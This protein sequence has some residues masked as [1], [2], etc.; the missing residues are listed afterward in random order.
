MAFQEDPPAGVPDW[1][2][3][4]GDMMSLLLTFFIML[5]SLSEVQAE[6][7]YRAVLEAIYERMGF[8]SGPIAPP[9]N[10]YPLNSLIE[11]LKKL[12]SHTKGL[13]GRGGIR[14]KGP[15][16]E[17][18]RVYRRKDGSALTI[19][20]ALVF[21]EGEATLNP[22]ILH[23]LRDVIKVLS[24]KPNKIEIRGH[25]SSKSLTADSKFKDRYEL[26]YARARQVYD[27][28]L[29]EGISA[30]RMRIGATGAE[31]DANSDGAT[32]VEAQN[33][34]V[35]ILVFDTVTHDFAGERDHRN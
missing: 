15:Q 3:T 10:Y 6:E 21:P 33:D 17:E 35:D 16:G 18:Y 24:G 34:R 30:E 28:L 5:V 22:K 26:S 14:A 31:A 25:A 1:I 20:G 12:G 23:S 2:L 9:G 29:A 13:K 7:K 4:Y 8:R 19:S 27:H 32:A 11:G